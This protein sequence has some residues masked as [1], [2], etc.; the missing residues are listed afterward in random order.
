LEMGLEPT[1]LRNTLS[2]LIAEK[3]AE[4]PSVLPG[5]SAPSRNFTKTYLRGSCAP[6]NDPEGSPELEAPFGKPR[7]RRMGNRVMGEESQ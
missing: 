2:Q 3:R 4:N 7:A 6:G 5:R 1:S